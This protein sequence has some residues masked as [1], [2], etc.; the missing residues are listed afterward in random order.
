MKFLKVLALFFAVF[1]WQPGFAANEPSLRDKI[2]QMLIIGFEGKTIA[3]DSPIV[4]AINENNIGGVIL[5]DYNFR[6]QR[7]DK[8]IAS[9]EQLRELNRLLQKTAKSANEQYKRPQSPLLISVDYEGGAVNR[10][11]P[12]Y[13]F[14][15]TYP[16]ADV[17]KMSDEDAAQVSETMAKT[18]EDMGFNLN[19]APV[20]DVNVNP[21]NPIIAKLRR[22]FSAN[23]KKV[24]HYA[25]IY[26]QHFIRHKAQCAYKHFPGHGSSDADSHLG[27]VDVSKSWLESE[28]EPYKLLLE[29]SD[30]CKMVMTAHI[31]N[32]QL[33]ESGRPATLSHKILT[34]LLRE[35]LQFTGVIITDD[36]Q[37][38]AITSHYS[39][40]KALTLAINAGAD[41][42]IF[43]NQLADKTQDPAELIDIVE[44]KVKS[45]EIAKS[46][47]DEAY[48]RIKAFKDSL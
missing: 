21:D 11:G 6:S 16:A 38:K 2:G 47:I 26:S 18:L 12:S 44:A 42:L 36:M 20:L 43:G 27:F 48:R 46:R 28:L 10:L 40:D 39:L 13:G 23:P 5:F 31:V 33:D 1:S 14:P 45:G 29:G 4:K 7:F 17:A 24:A 3:K 30:S 22:S 19:F 9:P 8:N 35:Q 37:M 25:S 41:M 34:G 15:P 32:R